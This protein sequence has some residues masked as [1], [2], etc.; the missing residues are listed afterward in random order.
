MIV[1]EREGPVMSLTLNRPE[2][3]N[4]M[5]ADMYA[6]LAEGMTEAAEDRSVRVLLVLGHPTAFSA[7]NDLS[8]FANNPPSGEDAPVQRFLAQVARFPKPLIAAPCSQVVGVGATL[9]LHCDLVYAADDSQFSFPF[10][11]L[12]LVPEA[13]STRLLP[14]L[15][16][17]PRA[18]E[19]L[20]FGEPFSAEEALAMGLVNRIMPAAEVVPYAR[21]RAR[22]LATRPMVSLMETKRLMRD[23]GGAEATVAAMNAE[24]LVFR[25]LLTAPAAREAFSAFLQKRKPDFSGI[26]DY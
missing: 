3:R 12:G 7:G 10:T 14:R 13:G 6:S 16:G 23:A 2:R 19:K 24:S 11:N 20:M 8:D 5:T 15:A 21:E 9:L 18:A 17:W 26:D 22:A 4:A 1:K 25:R